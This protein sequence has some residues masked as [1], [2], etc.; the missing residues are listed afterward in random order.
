MPVAP[1]T[2]TKPSRVLVRRMP[3][4][5]RPPEAT[6]CASSSS[7]SKQRSAQGALRVVHP[8]FPRAPTLIGAR[9]ARSD[10][11]VLD[12]G[13]PRHSV[14]NR[15]VGAVRARRV[16]SLVPEAQ[17]EVLEHVSYGCETTLARFRKSAT[18]GPVSAP[19]NASMSPHSSALGM[20]PKPTFTSFTSLSDPHLAPA[21]RALGGAFRGAGTERHARQ[22]QQQRS[23]TL[24][25]RAQAA[26]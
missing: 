24:A 26:R 3:R 10:R 6:T 9:L 22:P 21:A 8:T 14:W 20:P 19:D 7:A 15:R 18:E 12:M 2:R 4:A 23:P 11:A 13:A 16:R 5:W 17:G 25:R 1:K